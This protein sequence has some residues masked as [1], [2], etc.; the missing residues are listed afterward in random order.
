M[1]GFAPPPMSTPDAT[2]RAIV[3]MLNKA[4]QVEFELII[5]G[6]SARELTTVP[7][8][9]ISS[10]AARYPDHTSSPFLLRD[11]KE[12]DLIPGDPPAFGTVVSGQQVRWP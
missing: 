8:P 7:N 5:Y 3:P 6:Y 12:L 4:G 10:L 2:K 1:I 11:G 9:V